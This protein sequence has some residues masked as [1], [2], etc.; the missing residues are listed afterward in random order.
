MISHCPCSP[1]PPAL[2]RVQALHSGS[3]CERG[4][5]RGPRPRQPVPPGAGA[6]GPQWRAAPPVTLRLQSDSL[7]K[8]SIQE[9][10]APSIRPGG[11]SV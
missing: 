4:E 1:L 7:E 6:E 9:V 10:T 3:S 5:A 8:A 11:H 2:A